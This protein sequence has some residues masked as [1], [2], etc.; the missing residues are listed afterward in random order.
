MATDVGAVEEAAIVI[1]TLPMV[2]WPWPDD[3]GPQSSDRACGRK[4]RELE[5]QARELR[6]R[7]EGRV[8]LATMIPPS[9]VLQMPGMQPHG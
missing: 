4:C 5:W 7:Y 2:E 8:Q 1:Q 6:T 3:S 9:P